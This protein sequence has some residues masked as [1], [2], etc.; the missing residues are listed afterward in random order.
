MTRT[1]L[2]ETLQQ[3]TQKAVKDLLLPVRRQREDT[4]D[5]PPHAAQVFKTRLPDMK[6]SDRKA[7]Y[8]IHS[9]ITG[10]DSQM[11]GEQIT[12][13]A[14]VR[15]TF[16][17]YHEDEQEGGLALLNLTERLR[18]HILKRIVLGIYALDLR[19]GIELLVY[20]DDTAP[21]Y[22]ADMITQWNLPPITREVNELWQ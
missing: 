14:T 22:M 4:E 11:E 10:I 6:A 19:Q 15:S 2:L 17:V 9:L 21:Y 12:C 16:C 7:P 20:P 5:P 13:K 8:I 3:E 18:I 1:G